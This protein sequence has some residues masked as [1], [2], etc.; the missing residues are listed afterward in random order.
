MSE[1]EKNMDSNIRKKPNRKEAKQIN[2]RVSESEYEKLKQSAE[3]LNISVPAFCKKKA[4]GA[5]LVTPKF[6]KASQRSIIRDLSG[7]A[8]NINQI[9]KWCN[10]N[11]NGDKEE[12]NRNLK[13]IRERLNN[14][15]QQLS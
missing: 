5:R 3:T 12:L 2:F 10:T 14:V 15:W 9:A 1:L 8:N 4:Q 11:P 13:I 6:D 7:I